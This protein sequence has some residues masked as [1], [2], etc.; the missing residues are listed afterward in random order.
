[1][2]REPFYA[3]CIAA[4]S[5][6]CGKTTIALALM[7]AWRRRGKLVQA[8]KC[9]P[10]YI[11]PSYHRLATGRASY[12]LDTWMMG[13]DGVRRVWA[14]HAAEADIALCEGVMGLFDGIGPGEAAGSTADCALALDLPVLLV[15]PVRGMASSLVALVRGFA[16]HAPGLRVAGV[17][18][19]GVGGERHIALLDEV[20]EG[21]G[22]APLVGAFPRAEAWTLPERHLGLVPPGEVEGAPEWVERLADAA[23][24]GMDWERFEAACVVRRPHPLKDASCCRAFRRMAVARDEA[25]LFYYDELGRRLRSLGWETIEFS[26]LRDLEPPEGVDAIYLGGG[27]PEVFADA[28]AGNATMRASI[29][30]FA[31]SGGE[32]Y[33]ECGGYMYLCDEL[34]DAEGRRFP[35]CGVLRATARMGLSRRELGYRSVR[36]LEQAPF[37]LPQEPVR[38]HEFHWSDVELHADYKPL[39]AWSASG[40]RRGEA[41]VI[42]RNVRAGYMHLYWG[43][44]SVCVS[45]R[46][47]YES[48]YAPGGR[49]LLLNGA[50]SA[51]KTSLAYALQ[52]REPNAP[53]MVMSVDAFLS[54]CAPHSGR[55]IET[56]DETGLPL[57]AAFHAGI[58]AA[59][60]AGAW[61]IVD[62]VAGERL[63]WMR[64]LAGRLN[65]LPCRSV[66]VE[67]RPGVHRLREEGRRDRLPDWEHARR[68]AAEIHAFMRYDACVDTSD[69]SSAVCATQLRRV[70]T[71]MGFCPGEAQSESRPAGV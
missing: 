7:A 35:M 65:G 6:G 18:A 11:D 60:R 23:D 26:P 31:E 69:D 10:D 16:S 36:W 33:A 32:I 50:S 39:Y 22:L 58:A 53:W 20:L 1:M 5:S 42:Y 12:N 41:G 28:L 47:E 38:G 44:E 59:A 4:P 63:A 71:A 2:D 19:N 61:V 66:R 15:V 25:F 29:A 68:Q 64:D 13:R 37:G 27:Y 55:T 62:H 52:E 56:E 21:E 34:I 57:V 49:V 8:F 67:C 9:G 24:H 40:G 70:L 17:I 14:R 48:R 3:A 51:G 54:M 45:E 30:A 46:S 43:E